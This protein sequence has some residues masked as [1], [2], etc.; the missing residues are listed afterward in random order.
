MAFLAMAPRPYKMARQSPLNSSDWIFFS[1]IDFF[2]EI[3]QKFL[4]A[5]CEYLQTIFWKFDSVIF[6]ILFFRDD[7]LYFEK[8]WIY[9]GRGKQKW[10]C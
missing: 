1:Q 4:I 6:V 7:V 8:S 10:N 5:I 9:I 3:S 2:C